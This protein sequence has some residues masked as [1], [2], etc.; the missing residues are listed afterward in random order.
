M[1]LNIILGTA[2]VIMVALYYKR[3][4][5]LRFCKLANGAKQTALNR[6]D[7]KWVEAKSVLCDVKFY[8]ERMQDDSQEDSVQKVRNHFKEQ[9]L[10]KISKICA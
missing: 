8:F 6:S 5:T 3:S 9:I 10:F 2:L 4:R 7:S 1:T